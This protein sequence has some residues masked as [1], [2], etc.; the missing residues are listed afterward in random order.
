MTLV[1]PKE[2][3]EENLK[4]VSDGYVDLF[5]FVL[6]TGTVI[7]LKD[8]ET[9]TWSG[10]TWEG[11]PISL[12][13]HEINTEKQSRPVIRAVNPGGVFSSLFISGELEKA[14]VNRYRVLRKHIDED[15]PIYQYCSW[16]LWQVKSITKN[17]AEFEL[18]NPMDGNNFITPGRQYL[19][20]EFPT[21]TLG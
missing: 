20:P 19:P 3:R 18:R 16:I 12:F 14:R 21:V 2:Q 10:H 5:E 1:V 13:G 11:Y 7:Y 8:N 15:K 6:I 4:L 9:V 17:Y